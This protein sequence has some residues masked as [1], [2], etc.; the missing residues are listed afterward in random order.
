MDNLFGLI[1]RPGLSAAF[2]VHA[3]LHLGL[4]W[5]VLSWLKNQR[6]VLLHRKTEPGQQRVQFG[7][8]RLRDM[9]C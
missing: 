8:V 2:A 1:G 3:G 5:K 6:R 9:G 7:P 4:S